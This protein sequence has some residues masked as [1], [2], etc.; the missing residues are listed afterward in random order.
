MVNKHALRQSQYRHLNTYPSHILYGRMP[1]IYARKVVNLKV[2]LDEA[3]KEEHLSWTE[4]P[5]Y[6]NAKSGSGVA[7]IVQA[8]NHSLVRPYATISL[9][10]YASEA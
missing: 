5:I 7:E 3:S 2:R 8:S 4:P 9:D 1:C 6:G 10:I